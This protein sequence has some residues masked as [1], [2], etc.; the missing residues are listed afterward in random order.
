MSPEEL[1]R[2]SLRQK[3][4][5]AIN[6]TRE[7]VQSVYQ[8]EPD[9]R[10][11]IAKKA[12][13]AVVDLRDLLPEGHRPQ[14]LD[15][16]YRLLGIIERTQTG[17]DATAAFLEVSLRLFMEMKSHDWGFAETDQAGFDFDQTFE[18]YRDQNRIPELFDK[19]ADW[20]RKVV[21]SGEVDSIRV[22]NELN[23]IISTLSAARKGSYFATLGSW[24]FVTKWMKNTGWE[25]L[26]GITVLGPIFRGLKQTLDETNEGMLEM[27]KEINTELANKLAADF[28]RLEYTP[29]ELPALEA[30]EEV[31]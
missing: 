26:G 5:A 11:S 17:Y 1:Y 23:H 3:S 13:R 8:D 10:T 31:A 9:V 14:W 18:K 2:Q 28:P 12:Y 25:L 15:E 22:I 19:I 6:T 21:E 29:A 24:N 27:H 7:Y 30:T 20:L 16:L 4:A